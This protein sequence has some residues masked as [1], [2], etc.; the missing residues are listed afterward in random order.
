MRLMLPVL[1][2]AICASTDPEAFFNESSANTPRVLK[3]MCAEC[4]ALLPCGE[5][6]I[7]HEG[8]G[9]W[10]G[11]TARERQQIRAKRGIPIVRPE[12]IL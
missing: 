12:D 7:K 8:F 4:P 5:W 10:A 1:D 11:M 3:R 2:G 9:F 6:A